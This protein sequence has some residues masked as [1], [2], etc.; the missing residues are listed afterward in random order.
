MSAPQLIP[1]DPHD[2]ARLQPGG[3][4]GVWLLILLALVG[5]WTLFSPF[6]TGHQDAAQTWTATTRN[7]VVVGAVLLGVSL[8]ALLVTLVAQLGDLERAA[9]TRRLEER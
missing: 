1:H 2:P 9:R 4:L 8:M 6:L 3:K 5:A 7:D